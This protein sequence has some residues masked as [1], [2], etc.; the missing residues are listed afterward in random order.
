M[1]RLQFAFR[2]F[3]SHLLISVLIGAASAGLVFGLLYPMPYRDILGVSDIF[4]IILAV[5]VVCGPLLTLVLASPSKS[6]SERFVDLL[7][8]G[9]VQ[10][11]ALLYGLHAVW[12][13]RPVIMAFEVDRLVV[14]TANEIRSNELSQA[15]E[16]L[17][18]LPWYG[19][20]RVGTRAPASRDEL[21]KSVEL[22]GAGVSPGMIPGWWLP[23]DDQ[24]EA[25]KK[26]SKPLMELINR[27]PEYKGELE[28]SAHR[29]GFRA[30]DLYYLPLTSSQSLDWIVLF[31][32][33]LK[34]VGWAAVDGF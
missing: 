9:F 10:V 14:V 27:R 20:L 30:I 32:N 12:I 21:F 22:A 19:V 4:L 13:A 16:G 2:W 7:L 17:R 26:R 33:N 1:N 3:L 23:W 24:V 6:Q 25:I 5:D 28:G 31:D 15:P 18:S 11:V 29:A 34:M 8:V